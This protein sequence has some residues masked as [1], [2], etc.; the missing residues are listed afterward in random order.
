[1]AC[2]RSGYLARFDPLSSFRIINFCGCQKTISHGRKFCVNIICS[3]E[4]PPIRELCPGVAKT[5]KVQRTTAEKKILRLPCA[6]AVYS[7]Q[8]LQQ[9]AT[10][11]L[12][13]L[14]VW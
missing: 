14:L 8:N 5:R 7:S 12:N 2:A 3:D 6:R 4:L 1:M 11:G 10:K 9:N 13:Q